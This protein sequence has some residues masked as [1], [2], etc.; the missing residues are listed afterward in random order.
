MFV[1]IELVVVLGIINYM[2]LDF[3][4]VDKDTVFLLIYP[5][6]KLIIIFVQNLFFLYKFQMIFWKQIVTQIGMPFKTNAFRV[7]ITINKWWGP[8][9]L[10]ELGRWI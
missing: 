6:K 5:K 8:G 9:W 10:N 7:P 2:Y 4:Q 1:V 3:V